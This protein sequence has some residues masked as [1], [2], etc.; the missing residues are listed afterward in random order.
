MF[1]SNYPFYFFVIAPTP[2]LFN[3][4]ARLSDDNIYAALRTIDLSNLGENR[5]SS[6]VLSTPMK[7]QQF[8]PSTS[9]RSPSIPYGSPSIPYRSPIPDRLLQTPTHGEK[10][11]GKIQ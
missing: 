10:T 4:P 6:S 7:Q 5:T 9:Y 1:F 11:N 8:L 2:T 3:S